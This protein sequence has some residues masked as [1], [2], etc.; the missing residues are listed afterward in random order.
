[1]PLPITL[2]YTFAT[3]TSAIPL[4]NLDSDLST[5]TTAVNGLGSGTFTLDTPVLG[6]A[7]ATSISSASLTSTNT[8]LSTGSGGVGYSTGAGGTVTQITNKSTGVTLDKI[9]GQITM[10][11]AALAAAAEVIFTV[12]NSTIASTDV[13]IVNHASGGT[14]GAY[15]VGVSSI[16]SGS[17]GIAVSNV[18]TSSKNEAIVLNYV[19]IKSVSA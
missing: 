4:A 13:V 1:M 11:G 8:I 17:F 19:I 15:L 9:C 7:T 10:D 16:A 2:P 14:A 18:S 12:T 3:S 5:I 6:A